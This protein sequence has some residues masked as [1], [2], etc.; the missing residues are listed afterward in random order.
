VIFDEFPLPSVFLLKLIST[1]LIWEAVCNLE[2]GRNLV[3]VE[4]I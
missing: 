3:V 1:K 4:V 2:Y